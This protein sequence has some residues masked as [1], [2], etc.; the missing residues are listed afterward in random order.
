MDMLSVVHHKIEGCRGCG[1]CDKTGRCVINDDM[2]QIY[3]AVEKATKI[4]VSTPVYFYGLPAQGK[5]LVDRLQ[6]FWARRYKLGQVREFKTPPQGLV[7]SIGGT[8]GQDLFTPIILCAKYM[9]DSIS[10]PKKFPFVGFRRVED[11][12]DL[13][14]LHVAQI[15][16]MAIDFALNRLPEEPVL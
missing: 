12:K 16:K 3:E 14:P 4:V 1:A 6:I 2:S 9:F 8:K 15:E 13:S 5:A 11:P 7:M 10:F